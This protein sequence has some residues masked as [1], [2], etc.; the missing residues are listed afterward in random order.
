MIE[1][2]F[3]PASQFP[4]YGDRCGW[5]ALLPPR[6]ASAPAA[7][8]IDVKYA[9]IG[10]GY[11][12]LAAARRL[13][14]LDPDAEIVV[15]EATTVGEG[16]SARNSGFASPRDLPPSLSAEDMRQTEA[17]NRFGEEGYDWLTGL[18]ERH[19]ID[20]GLHVSGRIKG[21]ATEA[22]EQ[23]VRAMWRAVRQ[24]GA[25]HEFL[26]REAMRARIGTDYYRCG[27]FTEEGGL[28][29]PAALIRGLA[30]AL[31]ASVH[32]HENSPV[33]TLQR[34]GRWRLTTP[35]ARITADVVVMATNS[36]VKHF[37]YL[38]DRVVTIYTYAALTEAMAPADAAQLGGMASWGLLPAHRLGATLRRVGEDRLMVR[39]L[40]SYERGLPDAQ[41]R[42]TLT[43]CFH[44]RYP[45][46]AHVR[47]EHVWGGV[48][49]LTMNGAPFW[50]PIDEGLYAFAGCNGAGIVKGTVLG[51]RLAELI[52]GQGDQSDVAAAYGSASRVAP[53]PFRTIGFH[54]VSAVQ[55]RKAGLEM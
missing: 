7:G 23:V 37:G 41:V 27:L 9:V 26:D 21:A 44:R 5:N 8:E 28:L 18:M 16:A 49:A 11:T 33:D 10:A 22:G 36:A 4:D 54:F 32:L 47:L 48:T 55:R 3:A 15:L 53:E 13:A 2:R 45:A 30:D 35:Q 34:N 40:Y 50:G 14:E 38:R 31:P 42:E 20:C 46:L 24:L 25:P 52:A 19:G 1:T 17:L 51:K 12:G 29:Q 39:S 43:S 6:A